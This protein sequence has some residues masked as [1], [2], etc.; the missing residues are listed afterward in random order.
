MKVEEI[1]T[2]KIIKMLEQGT[3][4]WHKPWK[5]SDG[6]TLF[7]PANAVSNRPYRGVNVFL[8]LVQ[9]YQSRY[10]LTYK[11]A[12]QLGGNVKR[13]EKG[14]MI[15]FWKPTSYTKKN[16]DGST[17]EKDSLVLR[18]YT[19]FN[20]EQCENVKLPKG[21]AVVE[22]VDGM[23]DKPAFTPI[24]ACAAVYL[25]MPDRPML[26]HR[27]GQAYYNKNGDYI[28]LPEQTAFDSPEEYYS[29]LFHEM[30]HSTG[31]KKRLDRK[32][33]VDAV[34]FGDTNYS[35]EELVAEMGASF[36]A[37]HCGIDHKTL[38]NSAAYLAGWISKLK[39][40]PKLV[41]GAASAAQK[42]VDFILNV[43]AEESSESESAAA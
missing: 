39:G 19:V 4:P 11:Q 5:G 30:T 12:Q 24:E 20:T 34:A 17:E 6:Q 28:V 38:G 2:E 18:Y 7:P 41:I 33:L 43:K 14:T 13:G 29:T 31:A 25:N 8:L 21:R 42:A 37:G 36:L 16:D 40:E 35:K 32:T 3:V 10:W 26:Q 22:P 1:I 27:G 15:V 23:D 9:G